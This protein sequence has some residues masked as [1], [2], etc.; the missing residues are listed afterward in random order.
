M[1]S[2]HQQTPE[3]AYTEGKEILKTVYEPQTFVEACNIPQWT[4]DIDRD[5]N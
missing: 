2:V 3:E 5:Y 1:N 4:E